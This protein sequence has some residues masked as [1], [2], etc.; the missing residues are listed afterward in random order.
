MKRNELHFL[1]MNTLK[2]A[3]IPSDN[4]LGQVLKDAGW[5]VEHEKEVGL[6]WVLWAQDKKVEKFQDEKKWKWTVFHSF[7]FFFLL[8]SESLKKPRATWKRI[9]KKTT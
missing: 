6:D 9:K 4:L 3:E 7:L 1:Q 2:A 5:E 8:S